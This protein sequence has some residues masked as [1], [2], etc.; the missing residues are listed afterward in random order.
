MAEQQAMT[1]FDRAR[2]PWECVLFEGLPGGR[3]AQLMKMH[4]ST[5]DGLGGF[6]LFS[7]LHSTRREHDPDKPQ[8]PRPASEW[9]EPGDV[10][11]D[12]LRRD[13]RSF[14]R[15]AQRNA[16]TVLE[17]LRHPID[18][19]QEV[20]ELGSSLARVMGAPEAEGSPLLRGRSLSWRFIALDVGF[21]DLRAAAKQAGATLNDAFLASLL[22]AFRLYH[23]A[24]GEPVETIPI[25]I[26]ISVRTDDDAPG[27]NKFAARASRPRS[28][29]R[30][31]RSACTR[32]A[33]WC[34]KR[35]RSPL[36]TRCR[37]S[38]RRSRGSRP[39]W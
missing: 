39:R 16:E 1:P 9:V 22:G 17:G 28:A 20:A 19:A 36:S 24:L 15:N 29:R 33:S 32:S 35:A 6:Q 11:R 27:G 23:E 21:P 34:A 8:P 14:V 25:A 2:S 3:A 30:T 10:L 38:R 7:Q 13:F 5:T 37:P 12:Q 18:T 31:R 4:H 26:P